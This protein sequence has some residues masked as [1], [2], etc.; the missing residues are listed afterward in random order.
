MIK[1]LY[2]TT[3]AQAESEVKRLCSSAYDTTSQTFEVKDI[4]MQGPQFD[5]EY[6]SGGT[7]WNYE[8]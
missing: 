1:L 8:V 5:S 7:Y 4:N 6:Y 2:A 3:T